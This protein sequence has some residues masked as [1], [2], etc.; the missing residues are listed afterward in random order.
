M[1]RRVVISGG[2][3]FIGSHLTDRFLADGWRVVGVDNLSTG[4]RANIVHLRDEPRYE[5]VPA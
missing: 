1:S 2:A 3:G 5:L 4:K